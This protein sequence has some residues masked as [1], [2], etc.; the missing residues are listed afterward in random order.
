[1]GFYTTLVITTAAAAAAWW[2]VWASRGLRNAAGPGV[3]SMR[4]T[5]VEWCRQRQKRGQ[6]PSGGMGG[7]DDKASG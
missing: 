6:A 1:M 4:G 2:T 7:M 5:L 3:W